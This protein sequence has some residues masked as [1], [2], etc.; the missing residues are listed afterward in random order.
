VLVHRKAHVWSALAKDI[1]M[2][3]NYLDRVIGYF[4]PQAGLRRTQARLTRESITRKYDVAS[5][6]RRSG[7]WFSGSTAAQ[8]VSRASNDAANAGQEL[9]RNNPLAR[10]SKRNWGNHGVGK[11]IK[12]D[13]IGGTV[14]KMKS[15]MLEWDEW[16]ESADCDFEGHY[17]LYGLQWL[18]LTTV[19]E[20]GAVFVRAHINNN[21]D[22]PLQLQTFEQSRLDKYKQAKSQNKTI[23]DGVQY[24]SNGQ[25]EGYWF[26]TE[27]TNTQMAKPTESKFYK[28]EDI[29]HIYDKERAGQHLGMSWL[30]AVAH[31]LN[32]YNTSQ[33]AKLMQQQIAA[34]FALIVEEAEGASGIGASGDGSHTLPDAI[35]PA[36]IEY[37]KAGQTISTVSPPKVDNSAAFDVGI[38]QDIAM[39]VG[40][41]F[42]ML[43]GDYSR[44]NFA[45]GRMAKIDFFA[46]L[47]HIQEHML[48]PQLNKLFRWFKRLHVVK[49]G[50]ANLGKPT[51]TFPIRAAVNPKEEFDT[52]MAK[53]RHGMKSPSVA[54]KELEGVKFED[55]MVQW[56][57]DQ[58]LFNDLPF[59]IDPSM[60]ASTGNQLDNND[61]S[62][63]NADKVTDDDGDDG[64]RSF[65]DLANSIARSLADD[66]T[67]E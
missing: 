55:I 62:S 16:A 29:L 26:N 57:A 18:W 9:G 45:S 7:G 51:W 39:G 1:K 31:T 49:N 43:T 48:L 21:V 60:F 10:R 42:E 41:T 54:A 40:Q 24:N 23:I 59:D 47:D 61:A 6:G 4:N 67:D 28:Q 32:N 2:K 35:E 66:S 36:M 37:V 65:I 20:S 8:E 33:D 53:V 12:L 50:K 27:V 25:I 13:L 46:E 3:A 34:C 17:N 22:F 38:K 64:D 14:S 15:F 58:K 11:G 30:A 19:A 63:A 44:L 52:L 56:Q 5:K